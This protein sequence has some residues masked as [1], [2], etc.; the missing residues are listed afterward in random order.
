ME[1][2]KS[3]AYSGVVL[4]E[5]SRNRLLGYMKDEIP[6]DWDLITHH[7][8]INLGP[9]PD[10]CEHM[11]GKKAKVTAVSLGHAEKV[12]AVGVE[13][14]DAN[15]RSICTPKITHITLA[16]NRKDGGKPAMS[17]NIRHWDD[18][19]PMELTGTIE[20]IENKQS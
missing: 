6:T 19:A 9:L 15:L 5:K 17:N 10:G 13:V 4:D 12:C 2:K 3:I 20:E 18:I 14:N 7:M 1:D 8:T 11:I 16:V